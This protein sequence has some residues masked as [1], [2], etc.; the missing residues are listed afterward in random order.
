[1]ENRRIKAL[2]YAKV[3]AL[4]IPISCAPSSSKASYV[5]KESVLEQIDQ[6][7]HDAHV[8]AQKSRLK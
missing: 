5:E 1:M 2:Q 7:W 8:S 6:I 4:L 3:T